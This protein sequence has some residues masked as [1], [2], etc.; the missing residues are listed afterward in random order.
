MILSV[1]CD[2]LSPKPPYR[3]L[4][5]GVGLVADPFPPGGSPQ[6]EFEGHAREVPPLE[7]GLLRLRL[8][9]L[10]GDHILLQKSESEGKKRRETVEGQET[11]SILTH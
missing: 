10:R 5:D 6:Q 1:P 2:K 11:K 7:P 8:V 3:K 9:H 4:G